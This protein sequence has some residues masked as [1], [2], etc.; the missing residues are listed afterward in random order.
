MA[1]AHTK[2]QVDAWK[3]RILQQR[4]SG[5]SI[6][7]WCTDN[8]ITP[9]VFYYWKRRLSQEPVLKES[10]FTELTD[11]KE[12]L[13][14]IDYRGVQMRFQSATLKQSLAFIKELTC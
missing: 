8:Q 3:E 1:R 14:S 7:S 13:I 2:E 10:H 6:S 5:L 4:E 12:C 11:S 9:H